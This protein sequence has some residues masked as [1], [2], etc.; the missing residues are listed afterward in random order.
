[1]AARLLPLY[2]IDKPVGPGKPNLPDDVA[3]VKS[4]FEIL[5]K[6][7]GYVPPGLPRLDAS[8]SYTPA[9]GDTILAEQR[10]LKGLASGRERFVTDGFLSPI[11]SRSGTAGDWDTRFR[12]GVSSSLLIMNIW[13][14]K[15]Y[16]EQFLRIGETLRLPWV[17][18]PYAS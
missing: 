15:S 3:L 2:N 12:N 17:P 11:P 4:L 18:N 10:F 13:A 1:M 14:F 9:L 5:Q 16:P 6:S 7:P 8:R